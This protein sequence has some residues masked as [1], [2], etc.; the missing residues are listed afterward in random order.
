MIVFFAFR[1]N[2]YSSAVIEVAAGQSVV[3]TGPYAVLRHPM[4]AGALLL[5]F[6][7]PLALGS[8]WGLVPALL[9]LVMIVLRLLDEE[10]ALLLELP[11]YADYCRRVRDRLVPGVW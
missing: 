4:Y 11:G 5:V 10:T 2:S 7:T 9:M 3:T 1:A 8:W 6:C